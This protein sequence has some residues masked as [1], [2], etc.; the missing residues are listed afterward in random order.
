[1][2]P[3]LHTMRRA[4]PSRDLSP[5]SPHAE[6][7][8]DKTCNSWNIIAYV[9]VCLCVSTLCI[10]CERVITSLHVWFPPTSSL[11]HL[12]Q[13]TELWDGRWVCCFPAIR[14]CSVMLPCWHHSL[15]SSG[16]SKWSSF[17]QTINPGGSLGFLLPLT[18]EHWLFICFIYIAAFMSF[19]Q[20]VC[21]YR[22][23]MASQSCNSKVC[24]CCACLV[25]M[26]ASIHIFYVGISTQGF[27]SM[28]V[29]VCA[30]ACVC[31][32]SSILR[33]KI[34]IFMKACVFL[35]QYKALLYFSLP[36]SLYFLYLF[37]LCM[38]IHIS[39][40]H[41]S[42]IILHCYSNTTRFANQSNKCQKWVL[43]YGSNACYEILYCNTTLWARLSLNACKSNCVFTPFFNMLCIIFGQF[44]RFICRFTSFF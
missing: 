12:F 18:S 1:M 5:L 15:F 8:P 40:L 9:C 26:C 16:E 17:S 42:L 3:P 11:A 39:N 14:R 43:A 41:C 7:P 29:C 37:S 31:L 27:A 28:C 20:Q 44:H 6:N 2:F 36:L 34:N 13:F 4:W 25:C 19:H 30:R 38:W 35:V 10:A 22:K 32:L 23:L 24:V 33:A 21:L